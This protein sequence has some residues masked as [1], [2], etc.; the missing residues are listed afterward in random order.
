MGL[1]EAGEQNA[2]LGRAVIGG[3]LM[4]TFI[5][6][7]LVPAVY[8]TLRKKLPTRHLLD[9][10][11]HAEARGETWMPETAQLHGGVSSWAW[12]KALGACT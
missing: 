3:F 11:F 10:K 12:A 7:L 5:T 2:P 4:A 6:L 8:A 9:Q 1:G